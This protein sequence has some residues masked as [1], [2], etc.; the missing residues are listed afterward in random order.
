VN[1]DYCGSGEEDG[2]I[3]A[4]FEGVPIEQ[5]VMGQDTGL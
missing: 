1:I 4:K 5:D 3:P 2:C